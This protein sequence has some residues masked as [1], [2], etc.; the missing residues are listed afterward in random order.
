MR[1]TTS[2][3]DTAARITPHGE[4]DH[5]T[6]PALR[7]A[8]AALPHHVTHLTWDLHDA[9]FMDAA[10]LHLLADPKD[11]DHLFPRQ[12]TVIGLT[13]Q[14]QHLLRLAAEMFPAVDFAHLLQDA[15]DQ[16]AV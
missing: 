12:T 13:A 5:A 6:L 1:I 8:A 11:P 10:G 3:I 9:R 7:A 4:I 2:V 14:A 16:S 15:P